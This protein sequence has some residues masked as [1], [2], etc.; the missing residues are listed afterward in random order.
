MSR[1][2]LPCALALAVALL[3]SCRTVP[4]QAPVSEPW[5]AR[6]AQL[7]A[8]EHFEL[9]GRVAVAAAGEGFNARLRWVQDGQQA[10]LSLEGPLGA[11]GVQIVADGASFTVVNSRGERLDSEAARAELTSRL[12][13]EPPLTSFR[14]W[15]LGVPDPA[16]PA[17]EVLDAEQQ[18]TRLE[19]GGWQIE[20]TGYMPFMNQSLPSRVT[21][22]R[23]GVRV[24]LVVDSW[25][26]T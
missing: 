7:Q 21:L 17:T 3:A 15:M 2:L 14:Y 24:R 23:A 12:G 11:G 22:E 18:L 26:A 9:K 8:Q 25:T 1:K 19:Q 5:P 10:R 4:P 6:R 20:Y 16:Q 13:F